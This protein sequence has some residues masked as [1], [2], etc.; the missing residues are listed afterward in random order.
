MEYGDYR[1][2][3]SAVV[4]ID[5]TGDVAT[6]TPATPVDVVRVGVTGTTAYTHGSGAII[7]ADVNASDGDGTYTRGDGDGGTITVD[8]GFAAGLCNYVDLS[9]PVQLDPGDQLI[10]QV[11]QAAGAGDGVVWCEYQ[12]RPFQS[13]S[14]AAASNRLVNATD[15]TA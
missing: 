3:E 4:A 11:T 8:S 15:V 5:G 1:T 6:F 9:S 2:Y 14:S 13:G 12:K 10:F 7:K